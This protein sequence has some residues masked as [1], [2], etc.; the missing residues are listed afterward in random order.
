MWI[1]IFDQPN[2]ASSPLPI[3]KLLTDFSGFSVK[4]V[5]NKFLDDRTYAANVDAGMKWADLWKVREREKG[6]E[7]WLANADSTPY[8]RSNTH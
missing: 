5:F 1:R 8:I 3:P 4:T 7:K 6:G 2:Q